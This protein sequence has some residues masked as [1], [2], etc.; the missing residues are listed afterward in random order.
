MEIRSLLLRGRSLIEAGKYAEAVRTLETAAHR[1]PAF[2]DVHNLL[3]IALSLLGE[4]LRAES[5]L[6]RA[7]ELNPNFAEAHLN[8]AILLFERNAYAVARDHLREFDRLV[9]GT[10][11]GFPD[12]ALD[13]LATRHASLSDRYRAYGMLEE[14]ERQMR[15]AVRLRPGY[16]DLRLR[17]ARV[18][19]ERAKLDEAA[20]QL[21]VLQHQSPKYEEAYLLRG[22]LELARGNSDAAR[23]AWSHVRRGPAATQARAFLDGLDSDLRLGRT[24]WRTPGGHAAGGRP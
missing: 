1:Q 9:R 14:A 10:G 15:E 16:G 19:F 11:E 13:D 7:L 23:I 12:P 4:P 3:G 21:D 18:L 17:L 2:P 6:Q 8:L 20:E 5:H 24:G 22:R